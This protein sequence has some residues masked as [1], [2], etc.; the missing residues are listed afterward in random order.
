M[1]PWAQCRRLRRSFATGAGGYRRATAKTKARTRGEDRAIRVRLS[2]GNF[3]LAKQRKVTCRGSATHKYLLSAAEGGSGSIA[4]GVTLV[5]AQE[6]PARGHDF[7]Q[8][9]PGLIVGKV[10][11]QALVD[12]RWLQAINHVHG[13]VLVLGK[14]PQHI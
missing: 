10:R 2:F 4:S 7:V 1:F 12:F 14:R 8:V 3:S 11:T 5:E 6:F 13:V 9:A